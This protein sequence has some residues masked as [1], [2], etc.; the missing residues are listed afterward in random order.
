MCDFFIEGNTEREICH[1]TGRSRTSASRIIQAYHDY[2]GRLIN[3]ELSGRPK[4]TNDEQEQLIVAMAVV[5]P[6]LSAKEIQ[7]ELSLNVSCET[8]RRIL[9]EAGPGSCMAAQKPHLT[10]RQR[11]QRLEFDLAVE[12]RTMDEWKDVI[13]M[14]E[15]TFSTRWDQ[16]RHVWRPLSCRYETEL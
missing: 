3:A 11:L 5:D 7:Q 16:Q 9:K 15:S 1:L 14:D 4:V 2:Q 13:F 10:G 6:F 8:I 12:Q